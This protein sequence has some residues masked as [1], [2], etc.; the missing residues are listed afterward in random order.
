[1]RTNIGNIM[2]NLAATFQ[3]ANGVIFSYSANQ[4]SAG[5]FQDVSETF[6]CEK[7]AIYTSRQGY[8]LYVGQ[9]RGDPPDGSGRPRATSPRTQ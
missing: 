6:I 8:K 3:F 1:M 5:G 4:F 9:K 2:D 7:G